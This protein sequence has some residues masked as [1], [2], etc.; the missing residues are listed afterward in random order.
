MMTKTTLLPVFFLFCAGCGA[1]SA[2]ISTIEETSLTGEPEPA[3]ETAPRVCTQKDYAIPRSDLNEIIAAGPASL[4]ASVQTDSYKENG[5][6]TGFKIVSF[7]VDVHPCIELREDDIVTG[8]NGQSI[9][10]PEHYF[11]VFEQLRTAQEV[12]FEIIRDGK[13]LEI[14]Y[15]VTD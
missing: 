5:R 8:V 7:R 9:E 12:K 14:S 4:L 2:D 10:R 3:E 1:A 13:K 11:S 6:F 15:S